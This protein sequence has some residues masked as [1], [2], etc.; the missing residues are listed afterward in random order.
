MQAVEARLVRKKI[1]KTVRFEIFKRDKFTCQYCGAHPPA[2]ILEVDHI[3]PVAEGGGNE[4]ENLVT[5]C[6]NCNRGKAARLLT[7]VPKSLADKA[8]EVAEREEQLRG[9]TEIMAAKRD[10][11]EAEVWSAFKYWRGQTKTTH[12]KFN[13]MKRFIFHLGIYEVLDAIDIAM[14]SEISDSEREWRYFCGVCWNK[15]KKDEW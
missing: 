9:Y 15:I 13:S 3:V 8:A 7:A 11:V 4:D 1:G 6:F 2:V 14:A 5:S 10:R 12:N